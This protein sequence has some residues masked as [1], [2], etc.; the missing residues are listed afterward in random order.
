[1]LRTNAGPT[2]ARSRLAWHMPPA[3]GECTRLIRC[4]LLGDGAPSGNGA[5]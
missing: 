1:M 3:V 2:L 5:C 4:L